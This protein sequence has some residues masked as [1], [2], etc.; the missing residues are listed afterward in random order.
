MVPAMNR[1]LNEVRALIGADEKD[2]IILS[3]SVASP[4]DQRDLPGVW[5]DIAKEYGKNHFLSTR[6]EEAAK[7]L[8]S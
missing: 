6:I 3:P 7:A 2:Q 4:L 5:N 1:Y 8:L